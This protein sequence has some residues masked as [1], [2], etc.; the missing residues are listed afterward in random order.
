MVGKHSHQMCT[1]LSKL[2][3]VVHCSA[4]GLG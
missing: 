4:L 3:R 2:S 1:K